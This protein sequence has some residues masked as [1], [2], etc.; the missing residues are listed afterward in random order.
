MADARVEKLASVLVNY[1]LELKPGQK[2]WLRTTPLAEELNLAVYEEAVKAGAHIFVDQR[3]PG[4]EEIFFKY[5]SDEQLDHVS[6]L[7]Q[8][9]VETFDAELYI[10]AEHNSR[11]LSGIEAGRLAR[12]RKAVAPLFNQKMKRSADGSYRWCLTVYPTHSM[13]QEADMSLADY[14]EFVFGAGMLHEADPV[15]FWQEEGRKQT[16]LAARLQGHDQAALKGSN[17]DV[18]LSIKDRRFQISDGRYNFPDG[19]IFTSPVEDSVNGWIRFKYPALYDGQEVTDIELWF[20]EGRV[21]KE[22]A[23]KNQDLLTSLLNTDAGARI[24]GEWG[25]GTNYGIQHFSKNMLFDEKIGGTIHF[26]LGAGF[27]EC[28]G[29]NESGLHWD[30]LCDMA[31]SEIIVDGELFYR[32]GKPVTA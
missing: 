29:R 13:A 18:T 20:E 26:A 17:V 5:A 3:M 4:A 6:P 16:E 22:K 32:N 9:I 19:E 7:R 11:S 28:G 24:L 30:M 15:A 2:L 21:V 31:E 25:I 8:V 23:E 14:R 12:S 10:E 27:P 1:S